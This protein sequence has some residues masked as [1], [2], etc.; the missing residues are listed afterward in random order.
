MEENGQ[1]THHRKEMC[2]SI[3]VKEASRQSWQALEE[4]GILPVEGFRQADSL[5]HSIQKCKAECEETHGMEQIKPS[6]S[7][8]RKEHRYEG[9]EA[10]HVNKPKSP[11]KDIGCPVEE[12]TRDRDQPERSPRSSEMNNDVTIAE[13]AD[14]QCNTEKE[15]CP[16]QVMR[17]EKRPLPDLQR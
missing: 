6:S 1:E 7:Q 15:I 5:Q 14:Q 16:L 12:R 17:V 2:E 9:R 10:R 13:G 3:G 8:G 4:R 11:Q